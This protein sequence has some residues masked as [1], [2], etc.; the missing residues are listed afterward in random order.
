MNSIIPPSSA[1]SIKNKIEGYKELINSIIREYEE[2]KTPNQNKSNKKSNRQK[3]TELF[4]SIKDIIKYEPAEIKNELRKYTDPKRDEILLNFYKK[5]PMYLYYPD[6]NLPSSAPLTQNQINH[7]KELINNIIHDYEETKSNNENKSK[8]KNN[9]QKITDLFAIIN[10]IQVPNPYVN[11]ELF[12]KSRKNELKKYTR[13][14]RQEILSNFKKKY[15]INNH[16][17]NFDLDNFTLGMQLVKEGE[18]LYYEAASEKDP[19]RKETLYNAAFDIFERSYKKHNN[20]VACEY[21]SRYYSERT[22]DEFRHNREIYYI[23]RIRSWAKDIVSKIPKNE[24][25]SKKYLIKTM[26]ILRTIPNKNNLFDSFGIN[27]SSFSSG[28][29]HELYFVHLVSEGTYNRFKL[30]V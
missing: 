18:K 14:K 8:K 26:Q 20:P 3:I 5:Y 22:R 9:R 12:N 29:K 28:I 15:P 11:K 7:Y 23:V 27:Y 21:I 16:I 17:S 4:A 13:P 25:I 10:K 2:T 1:P 30:N 6:S 24:E 19:K